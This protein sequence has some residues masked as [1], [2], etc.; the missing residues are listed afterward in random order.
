VGVVIVPSRRS[1]R[2]RQL[3]IALVALAACRTIPKEARVASVVDDAGVGVHLPAAPERIV[4]LIPASTEL[5]FALGEGDRLVGRTAW[6]DWPE[7]AG[8]IPNLGN[9]IDPSVEAVVGTR[10]DLVLLYRSGSNRAAAERLR[11]FRIPVLE[12]E[13]NTLDDF[14]RITRLLGNVL[15]VQS[16]ADSLIA[17]TDS[18]LARVAPPVD[19]GGA[20]RPSVFILVW[21]RPPMALGKGSFLSEIVD[22]AGARNIFDDMAAPSG[23]V[24]IEAVAERDPDFIL[25]T[26]TSE[27]AFAG[28]SEWQV[29]RAARER[30]FLRVE[31]SEYN[32]PSPRM[33]DAVRALADSLRDKQ[34]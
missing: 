28:R 30:R 26:G 2:G 3:L 21:D 11:G 31:G 22:R 1:A 34:R 7:D 32:R 4:S 27:P 12:L 13:F 19:T 16:R 8:K 10:P 6:C 29:V 33:P 20:R 24:S 18:G 17:R 9:G 15:G 14:R 23:P 25:T 5:V